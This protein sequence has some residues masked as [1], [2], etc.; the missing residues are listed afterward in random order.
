MEKQ[1]VVCIIKNKKRELLLQK[2]T[3]DYPPYPGAWSVIGGEAESE[4]LHKEMERE[5]KEE[6]GIKLK[7]KFIFKEKATLKR[8]K[9][10]FYVFSAKL[11]EISRIKIGEGAGV[12]FFSKK[13]L[14][15]LNINPESKKILNIYLNKF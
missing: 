1:I 6:I 12:A 10:I 13:E 11:N 7:P 3:L 14:K 2:K 15:K 5:I 8:G 9:S 4:N